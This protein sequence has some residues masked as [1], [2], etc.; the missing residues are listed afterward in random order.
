MGNQRLR[1]LGLL[2]A[3]VVCNGVLYING[4]AHNSDW[5]IALLNGCLVYIWRL[6][7]RLPQEED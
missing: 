3:E 7:G 2:T 4:V 1:W 6:S 5:F